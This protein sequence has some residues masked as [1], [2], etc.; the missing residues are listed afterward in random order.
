VEIF[1]KREAVPVKVP[2][3][4]LLLSQNFQEPSK[5]R[6]EIIAE[7]EKALDIAMKLIEPTFLLDKFTIRTIDRDTIRVQQTALQIGE[8]THL[9]NQAAEA[10]VYLST[11][12]N[13]LEIAVNKLSLEGDFELAYWLDC[14][15]VLALNEIDNEVWAHVENLAAKTGYGVGLSL[16]PGSLKGW[17]IK[18]QKKLCTLLDPDTIGVTINDASLL[19]PHK[20]AS[21][22]IGIGPDYPSNKVSSACDYCI[23]DGKCWM[24]RAREGARYV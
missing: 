12:G 19:V 8:S 21:S 14:A 9:L 22:I 13:K 4:K 3:D 24:R 10:V 15:G 16:S 6:P 2:L 18:E 23:S 11:I 5:I 1:I 7:A 17:D 20:S